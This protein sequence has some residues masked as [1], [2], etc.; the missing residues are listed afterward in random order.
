[1]PQMAK[2]KSKAIVMAADGAGGMVHV[3]DRRFDQGDWPIGF[4]VPEEQADTWLQY[5]SAEC[6]K[7]GWSCRS[8]G[9]IEAKENSGSITVNTGGTGQPQLAVVWERKRGGPIKVRARSAGTPQFPL[10]Q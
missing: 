10:D 2:A 4:E 5:F 6:S 8:I 1:M 9:Q 7:R 3:Q